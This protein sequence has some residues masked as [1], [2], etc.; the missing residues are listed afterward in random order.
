V[1]LPGAS[2][3]ERRSASVVANTT[4]D[5][6]ATISKRLPEKLRADIDLSLEV[7]EGDAGCR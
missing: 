3:L 1:V 2:T 4:L 6:F 5:L 7:P